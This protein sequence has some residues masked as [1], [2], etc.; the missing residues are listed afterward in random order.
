MS[1]DF[2]KTI[3]EIRASVIKKARKV[4]SKKVIERWLHSTYMGW[5]NWKIHRDTVILQ[6]PAKKPYIF[7]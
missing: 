5:E 6:N 3:E 7:S 4:Y 1:E 2:D